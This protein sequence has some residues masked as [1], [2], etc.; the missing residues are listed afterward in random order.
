MKS[1]SVCSPEVAHTLVAQCITMLGID[2][3]SFKELLGPTVLRTLNT[4]SISMQADENKNL[5]RALPWCVAEKHGHW[6]NLERRANAFR[7]TCFH[8][9]TEYRWKGFVSLWRLLPETVTRRDGNLLC[10]RQH[11]A[12]SRDELV[13]LSLF[14][15]TWVGTKGTP[16]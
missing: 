1:N 14:E 13:R 6:I 7:S 4:F 16:T 8:T 3:K 15:T 12:Y 2:W 5:T 9:A 11:V 10:E